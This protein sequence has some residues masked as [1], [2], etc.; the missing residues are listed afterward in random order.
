ME[1]DGTQRIYC[2][3]SGWYHNDKYTSLYFAKPWKAQAKNESLVEMHHGGGVGGLLIIRKT[4]HESR[5]EAY[6]K[7]LHLPLNFVMTLK[8]LKNNLFNFFLFFKV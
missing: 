7:S 1:L 2:A 6:G 4:M 5:Q 3:Y 8:L